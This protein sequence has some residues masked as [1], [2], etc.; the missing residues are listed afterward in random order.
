MKIYIIE[1]LEIVERVA[2]IKVQRR[3]RIKEKN[4]YEK[5]TIN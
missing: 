4:L 1:Y 2:I 3:S 5:N